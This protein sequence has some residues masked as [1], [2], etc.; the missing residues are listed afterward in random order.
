[1]ASKIIWRLISE[2]NFLKLQNSP[3]AIYDLMNQNHDTQRK[4]GGCHCNSIKHKSALLLL[5]KMH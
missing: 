1:M 3:N 5:M 2:E 4:W